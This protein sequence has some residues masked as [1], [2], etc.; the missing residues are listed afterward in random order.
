[1]T[2]IAILVLGVV[3]SFRLP[4]SLMPDIDIP[5]I[6]VQVSSKNTSAR[7][8]ENTVIRQLRQQLMQV[9]HLSDIKSECSDGSGTIEMDFEH[10][11]DIDYSFIEV[12]EKIDRAMNSLPRDLARP[13]VI[14][15]SATDIPVFYLNLT[16][17]NDSVKYNTNDE[18]YPVSHKFTELSNFA[19]QVIRRRMEQLSSV[20]MVD[21]S[22]QIFP[23][24]L[25]LPD[26]KKLDALNIKLSQ[27]EG[28]INGN[29]INL[30]NLLINNGQYQY[31]I[32]FSSSLRNK[33]DIE[34]IYLKIDNRL[35]QLK[36]IAQ[37]IDH[38]QKPKGLTTSEGRPSITMAVIKQS[39]AQMRNLKKQLNSLIGNFE[40]DYPHINFK[41][42][43]NQTQL[44]DYSIS[45]LGQSLMWGAILAFLIMFLFLKD[46]RSPLLIGITIPTSL[47]ISLLLFFVF[48]ISLNI[49]SLSG[50]VLG[51]G[52]MIDNSIIVIDNITQNR[53][54]GLMLLESCSTGT[55][56]V[57]RP[58]LSS[59]LT[60]CAVFIPLIFI[61]GISGALFYDQAMAITIGLLVSLAVSV[62][63]LPVYYRLIYGKNSNIRSNKFLSRI[64][65]LNYEN[66][67][68]KGFK[69]VMRNQK[70]MWALFFIMLFSVGVLFK[71]LNKEKLP[72]ITKTD[73]VL[74][75]DW[76]D[77]IN[78]IENNE[79]VQKIVNHLKSRLK[80]SSSMV[81]E[82]QFLLDH[83]TN[84]STAESLVY[85][86]SETSDDLSMIKSLTT[87]YISENF[88]NAVFQFKEAGTIFDMLFSDDS[89]PLLAKL[90]AVK[91]HGT[92]R[93]K[94]LQRNL[95]S[96]R[97]EL[98]NYPVNRVNWKENIVF[99]I[100]PAKLMTYGITFDDVYRK[101]KSAFNE[102]QILTIADN[103]SFVPV[104]LGGKPK[105]VND[106]LNEIFVTNKDGKPIR[107]FSLVEQDTDFDLKSIIA[108]SEGEYYPVRFD[109]EEG[110]VSGIIDVVN[111][112]LNGKGDFEADFTGQIFS[113]KKLL[114][115][116][117]YILIISLL[118]L[119]FILA[120]QFE[121][122]TLPFIVLL[123]VPVD[124]FGAFLFLKIFG[125]SIN[126]MS[127]IGIIVMCGIIINDS[128]LKIDTINQLRAQGYTILRAIATAGQRRLKPILMTSL[129][130]ILALFPFLFI[131]GM[132]ADLQK[133]LAL[134]VIGGMT[135]GTLVSLYFIPLCYYYLKRK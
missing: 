6:T 34:D 99:K 51:V 55:N 13:R 25:V 125:G 30:G 56:E 107:L 114:K 118:L 65:S 48:D 42:S 84:S 74:K 32:R 135:I 83:N 17:K 15:A 1:M 91:E 10:G 41:I 119:Y 113:N 43:R 58:M 44:L 94:I 100:D 62:T 18:L 71:A 75:I 120:A 67:Y 96:L 87:D 40:K 85:F 70:T 11:T 108:G 103:Q 123:E 22:G 36:E 4:V 59:V 81:G 132:G 80:Y 35:I 63:L 95:S 128:I 97:K 72:E 39:D 110:E 60:T 46:F 90:R 33:K 102:N 50:L 112:V 27:V 104:I 69:V 124:I 52:M 9:A 129:T 64:N 8:L 26:M 5:N 101:F 115:E 49:I 38:P 2:F 66:L 78:V 117:S 111:S 76:N 45:N 106:I 61:S 31:N 21:V 122:L 93:N 109:V 126:L 29:N 7:E 127:L 47:V 37:V 92:D 116:L 88:S 130:T 19:G 14:K 20:A 98:D 77:N 89:P 86:E 12:N 68:E 82:Q 57:F 23:E 54:R 133:P 131:S 105:L 24:L 28:I 134:A 79:R 3:A 121:S 16:L 53:E 73:I